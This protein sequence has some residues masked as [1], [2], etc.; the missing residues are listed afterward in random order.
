[1]FSYLNTWKFNE[2]RNL[3][4]KIKKRGFLAP[5]IKIKRLPIILGSVVLTLASK[6]NNP[7]GRANEVYTK[8]KKV[9]VQ[10]N[11]LPIFTSPTQEQRTLT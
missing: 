4:T 9:I 2:K 1:M 11:N 10:R 7:T 3:F 8:P 5:V 6:Y